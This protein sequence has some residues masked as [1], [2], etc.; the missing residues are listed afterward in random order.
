[1]LKEKE[2]SGLWGKIDSQQRGL[3]LSLGSSILN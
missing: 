3:F 1:M 2:F